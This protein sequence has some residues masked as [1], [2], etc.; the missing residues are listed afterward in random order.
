MNTEAN[1]NELSQSQIEDLRLAAKKMKG[2]SRRAFQAESRFGWGRQ[3][4][5]T[6]LEEKKVAL[7]NNLLIEVQICFNK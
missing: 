4:V 6:G 7:L 1:T 5:Q 3:S 2:A